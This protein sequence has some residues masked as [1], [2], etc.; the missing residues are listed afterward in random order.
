V[1]NRAQPSRKLENEDAIPSHL[2]DAAAIS[3]W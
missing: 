2:I 1:P 3:A